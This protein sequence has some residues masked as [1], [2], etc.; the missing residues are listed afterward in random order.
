MPQFIDVT[1]VSLSFEASPRRIVSLV[2]S[3]TETLFEIGAASR[4]VGRTRYCV[5]PDPQVRAI[6]RI[7]GTKDPDVGRIIALNPDL[8]LANREENRKQDIEQLRAA[9]VAVFVDEPSTVL[10]GLAMVSTLGDML[11]C[12]DRAD[13]IVRR[14]AQQLSAIAQRLRELE[15][16]NAH[17]LKPRA[18]WRPRVL[19]F[20]WRDPWMVAGAHTYISDMLSTLGG[21]L[22]FEDAALTGPLKERVAAQRYFTVDAVDVAA[23][24]PD[25]LLFPDEPYSFTEGDL[26]YRRDR[27]LTVPAAREGRLRLCSGQ[28]LAWFGSRTPGALERLQPLVSW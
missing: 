3:V 22:P 1:G 2:P 23:L 13:A 14:G 17:K 5:L 4:I 28:D 20:I 19:A 12:G 9:G 11:D 15:E 8:V 6:E 25:I 7:G 24:A 21:A 26:A 10:Q 27:S 16:Q 18:H